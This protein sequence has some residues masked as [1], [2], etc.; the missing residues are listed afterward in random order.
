MPQEQAWIGLWV[1]HF[2]LLSQVRL[3]FSPRHF[4]GFCVYSGFKPETS[5]IGFS[6]LAQTVG[7]SVYRTGVRAGWFAA[8]LPGNPCCTGSHWDTALHQP[9]LCKV[10]GL[11]T[12]TLPASCISALPSYQFVPRSFPH[13]LLSTTA[14]GA[15][16]SVSGFCQRANC[17]HLCWYLSRDKLLNPASASSPRRLCPLSHKVLSSIV[18]FCS[19]YFCLCCPQLVRRSEHWCCT[20]TD[21]Q[22]PLLPLRA[23]HDAAGR[24]GSLVPA[25]FHTARFCPT[26]AS[27]LEPLLRP[28]ELSLL[29]TSRSRRVLASGKEQLGAV[30]HF[31]CRGSPQAT[32]LR[33]VCW[34]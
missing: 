30:K 9:G 3:Q 25:S 4:L 26:G 10:R 16:V 22:E 28:P 2:C 33:A 14:A 17:G 8:W 7:C 11:N 12:E 15:G 27:A 18:Y 5:T 23:S 34:N 31:H 21:K 19:S 29:E 20:G 32:V 6:E 24:G 13:S 1:R